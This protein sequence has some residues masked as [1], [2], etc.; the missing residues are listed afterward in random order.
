MPNGT[1]A[2]NLIHRIAPRAPNGRDALNPRQR[3]NQPPIQRSPV[4]HL[5]AWCIEVGGN[6]ITHG[7]QGLQQVAC[8]DDGG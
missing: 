6:G 3:I 4:T 1:P 5:P 2:S 8:S 7:L